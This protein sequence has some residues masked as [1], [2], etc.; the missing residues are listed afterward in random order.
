[1]SDGHILV[2]LDGTLAVSHGP[3]APDQIGEIVPRMAQRV[4]NWLAQG[5]EVRIF[6]VRVAPHPMEP[7]YVETARVAIAEWTRKHFG[8]ELQSTYCKECDTLE[9]WDDRARQVVKNQGLTE[10]E[11]INGI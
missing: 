4:R 3:S 2:D 10:M 11:F 9:I 1:M 5:I 6:T 8:R 7:R